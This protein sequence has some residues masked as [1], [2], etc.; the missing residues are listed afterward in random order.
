MAHG[1]SDRLVF[2]D[3]TFFIYL[4]Y[5]LLQMI[6]SIDLFS[7]IGGFAYALRQVATPVT[8]CEIDP[9]AR[10]ILERN[11]ADGSIP[12]AP[13]HHDIQLL[14]V[15]RVP[16]FRLITAGF[17]CQDISAL[18]R[19]PRGLDG[20]RSGLFREI[21]RII[22]DSWTTVDAVLLENS[23]NI[24][25]LGIRQIIESFTSRGYI[26]KWGIW[27]AA[28]VGALHERKR[29]FALAY[30][31]NNTDTSIFRE[32]HDITADA[33]HWGEEPCPRVIPFIDYKS[34]NSRRNIYKA[35]GNAIVPLQVRYAVKSLIK[36]ES[37]EE[38]HKT[39]ELDKVWASSTFIFEAID[40]INTNTVHQYKRNY[41]PRPFIYPERVLRGPG[42][43]F[44]LRA[45]PTPTTTFPGQCRILHK[46]HMRFYHNAIYYECDTQAYM[47]VSMENC[48]YADKLW[49]INPGFLAYMMGYPQTWI[50]NIS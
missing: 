40:A 37:R 38:N 21:L 4:S 29:W 49:D 5:H 41:N 2:G 39:I 6:P 28:E 26:V 12:R 45:W 20:N 30:K 43:Q 24:V 16:P 47:N 44:P 36:N 25:K 42:I 8:Y 11:M 10:T 46:R 1:I 7:G 35:F 9:F 15:H 18:Q 23:P 22:D 27:S 48:R 17:P 3:L 34:R 50:S 33:T 14:D 13:I 32:L 31:D 19:N